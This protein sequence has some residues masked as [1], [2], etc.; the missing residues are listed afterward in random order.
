MI[1]EKQGDPSKI[2]GIK[3]CKTAEEFFQKKINQGVT[4]FPSH[5]V[6]MILDYFKEKKK[7]LP[8][9]NRLDIT[10]GFE[11]RF[12]TVKERVTSIVK[13]DDYARKN[14]WW[15]YLLY[16]SKMKQIKIITKDNENKITSP[17]TVSRALRELVKEAKKG[18][19][20]LKFL[21]KDKE[22]LE[23]R[24]QERLNYETYFREKEDRFY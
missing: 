3:S 12:K 9:F 16:L 17:E 24:E 11:K 19:E 23:K 14:Y 5:H 22:T 1:I 13:N 21:L 20:K 8:D 7:D 6:Q 18:D 15:L 2:I 10:Q 4:D